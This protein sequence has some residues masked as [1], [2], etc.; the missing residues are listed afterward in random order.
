[1][2]NKENMK[3][4]RRKIAKYVLTAAMLCSVSGGICG[5][6][7]MAEVLDT[8]EFETAK[9]AVANMKLG[10]NAGNALDS[11]GSWITGED[12]SAWETAWGSPLLTQELMTAIAE[13]NFDA[14]RV[15]VTW[16]DH[17][18][19]N[20]QVDEAWM[21]RVEEVVNYV[22]SEDMY[23]ILNVHHDCGG[24]DSA[25]LQ[26]DIEHIEEIQEK[27]EALWLQIAE[28]FA[29]YD[30]KLIFEG[31]NEMLDASLQWTTPAE[32]KDYEAINILAQSFVDTVRSTGGNNAQR[33]LMICPYSADPG[34]ESG[35]HLVMPTDSA[36][37]HLM[38]DVH[39]YAPGRFTVNG[40][41][42]DEAAQLELN[43][44]LAGLEKVYGSKG[45]PVVIGEFGAQDKENDEER[46]VY[47]NY[48]LREA[49]KYDLS[50]FWWDNSGE[51]SLIDRNGPIWTQPSIRNALQAG[52]E[53]NETF[54]YEE[55]DM[56]AYAALNDFEEP[57]Y[58]GTLLDIGSWTVTTYANQEG[59]SA[60]IDDDVTTAWA[61][62]EAQL[63][64][65]E[66]QWILVDLGELTDLNRV[67]LWTPNS[68]YTRAY[69]VYA[70]EDGENFELLAQGEGV[71]EYLNID[72]N[73]VSARYIRINQT[74]DAPSNWW[75][76]YEIRMYLTE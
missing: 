18:D 36:E 24:S 4:G 13:A 34:E 58:G 62:M 56:E 76:V 28:R 17:M 44:V 68:D 9:E 3:A 57:D 71:Q 12:V 49:A 54:A 60:L 6:E 7:L 41:S 19:E 45:I 14:V 5:Q 50:C 63:P 35:S 21:N 30:E 40:E 23:C 38:V 1:M 59:A 53:G 20:Y 74:G 66:E 8:D 39:V 31:Y 22:L 46:A 33:N 10:W 75:S 70:S 69:E 55:V 51:M 72:F 47:A 37:N 15:P 29:E 2:K 65:T 48:F 67:M 26:A 27:F 73:A 16:M 25:W 43:D 64:G 52:A 11:N 61:N 42:F 32:E